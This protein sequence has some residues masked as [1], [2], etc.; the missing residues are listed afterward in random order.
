MAGAGAKK[1]SE[2]NAR[3]VRNVGIYILI[4][5][6]V[7]ALI[8]L[9]LPKQASA[10]WTTWAAFAGTMLVQGFC[11]ISIVAVARPVY[12]NG[13]LVDGGADLAK[14]S[15]SYYFDLLYVT[16]FVQVLASFTAYGWYAYAVVPAYAGF[17]LFQFAKPL[18][19]DKSSGGE[20]EMDEATRKKLERTQQRAERRRVKRF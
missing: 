10:D 14:G 13:V 7:F 17:K 11:Y 5:A 16:G 4:C 12:S 9:Y 2:E 15:I 8:R 1:R 18:L 6:A 20:V 19:F 3:T